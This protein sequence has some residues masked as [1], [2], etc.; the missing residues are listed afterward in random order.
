MCGSEVKGS[1]LSSVLSL[2]P[3]SKLHGPKSCLVYVGG[4]AE[5]QVQKGKGVSMNKGYLQV[6]LS[7]DMTEVVVNHP[8]L[9]PDENGVGHIVFSIAEARNL[10]RLLNEKARS[11]RL[12]LVIPAFTLVLS[13]VIALLTFR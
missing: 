7:E 13:V 4:D 1:S 10:A 6:G 11:L 2:T 9:E 8:D 5:R 12:M 3:R